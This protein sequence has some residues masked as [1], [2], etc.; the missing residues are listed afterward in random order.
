[1]KVLDMNI[2][3]YKAEG[4]SGDGKKCT[5]WFTGPNLKLT[6]KYEIVS[7]FHQNVTTEFESLVTQ[8]ENKSKA[9]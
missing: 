8:A 7:G 2:G 6:K 3:P 1:M 4:H 9:G 5:V